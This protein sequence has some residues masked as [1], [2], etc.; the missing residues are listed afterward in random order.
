MHSTSETGTIRVDLYLNLSGKL[1][2]NKLS[3]IN[4]YVKRFYDVKL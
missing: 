4:S 2:T 1:K 3:E